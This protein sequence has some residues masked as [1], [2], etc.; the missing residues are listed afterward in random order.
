MKTEPSSTAI[1]ATQS[2]RTLLQGPDDPK[3]AMRIAEIIDARIAPLARALEQALHHLNQ[4]HPNWRANQS[5]VDFNV[6]DAEA[7]GI[8]AKASPRRSNTEMSHGGTND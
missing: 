2:I 4:C 7:R 5:R 6:F 1:V 3:L 8:L